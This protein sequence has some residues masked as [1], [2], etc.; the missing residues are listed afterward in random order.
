MG[1]YFDLIFK[2]KAIISERNK[3]ND[4]NKYHD[5]L[6]LMMNSS[7]KI[8]I[9]DSQ[10]DNINDTELHDLNEQNDTN[11]PK[12][13]SVELEEIDI[14]A[15]SFLFFI[16]GYETTATLLSYLLHSLAIYPECQQKLYNEIISFDEK[17]DYDTISRMPYLDACISESLRLNPPF[18]II[19]RKSSEDYPLG[20]LLNN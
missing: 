1:S 13:S 12:Y 4:N 5:I 14:I 17:L 10:E 15:N 2:V 16:A 8:D 7:N 11:K 9:D 6:Q 18:V 3:T 20:K 19:P